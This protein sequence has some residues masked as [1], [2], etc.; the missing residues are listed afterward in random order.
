MA[1]RV[2]DDE[3]GR[4]VA[5]AELFRS[6]GLTP[7]QIIGEVGGKRDFTADWTTSGPNGEFEFPSRWVLEPGRIDHSPL[8]DWIH[9]DYGWNFVHTRKL[10]KSKIRIRIRPDAEKA[11]FLSEQWWLVRRFSEYEPCDGTREGHSHCKSFVD[12]LRGLRP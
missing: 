7:I 2:V 6:Y 11:R 1:G 4:G 3:T 5:G 9:K 12:S 10:D 8:I